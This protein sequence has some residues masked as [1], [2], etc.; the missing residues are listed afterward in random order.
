MILLFVLGLERMPNTMNI[1]HVHLWLKGV[2][3]TYGL[4]TLIK[5]LGYKTSFKITKKLCFHY[6]SIAHNSDIGSFS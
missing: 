2:W 6:D 4:L 5:R 1:D 3:N